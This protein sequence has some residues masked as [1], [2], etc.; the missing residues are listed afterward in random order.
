MSVKYNLEK[1]RIEISKDAMPGSMY[2]NRLYDNYIFGQVRNTIKI[3]HNDAVSAIRVIEKEF[4]GDYDPIEIGKFIQSTSY[5][6]PDQKKF[7]LAYIGKV[8]GFT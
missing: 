8:F 4:M 1:E 7:A 5:F 2:K 6:T 3:E